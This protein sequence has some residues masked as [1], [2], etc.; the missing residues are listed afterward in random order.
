MLRLALPLLGLVLALVLPYISLL[1]PITL[2]VYGAL[3][4][5][6]GGKVWPRLLVLWGFVLLGALPL[7]VE[8]SS[9]SSLYAWGDWGI[10]HESIALGSLIVLRAITAVGLVA[11]LLALNPV[12]RLCGELRSMGAPRLLVE[13]IELSYRYINLLLST[14]EHIL[15]AQLLRLG[16]QSAGARVQHGGT[17][18]ARSFVL[19]HS[20][21]DDMYEGLLSRQ[22]DGDELAGEQPVSRSVSPGGQVALLSLS[23]LSYR[24]DTERW[25]IRDLSLE[26]RAGE[27]IVLLGANGAGKST[28]MR[29][30]SGLIAPSSGRLALEGEELRG[31]KRD[32]TRQ[33]RRI[34]LVMQNAN[35]QLFCPSVEDEIAFGLKNIGLPAPEVQRRV[36]EIITA[37]DLEALRHRPPHLL[38]EGQK[39][40][41]SIAAVLALDPDIILLDEPTASL[42][43]IYS[44]RVMALLDKLHQAGK[45]IILSTHDMD[46]AYRW[47]E[48]AVVLGDGELLYDGSPSELFA[49]ESLVQQARI[50]IPYGFR[51]ARQAPR[52]EAQPHRYTLALYHST[53]ARVLVVGGGRGA[54]I[55]VRTLMRSGIRPVLLSPSLC[56]ELAELHS[57]AGLEWHRE[58]YSP[59][60]QLASYDLVIAGTGQPEVDRA[61]CQRAMVCSRLCCN[62]SEA[63]GGNVQF[64]AQGSKAGIDLALHSDYRL[65]EVMVALRERLLSEIA[66]EWQE[67]LETLSLLR[68]QAPDVASY[69]T[70]RDT[71]ITKIQ[72]TKR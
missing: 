21:A 17:L 67:E 45:T 50:A 52:P 18:L 22:F 4:G 53:L 62:L 23:S 58:T 9:P 11:L 70:A 6:K 12:Y 71:L 64:A 13:L 35:Y 63:D 72:E 34:A 55:K 43:A 39:K 42:D 30:L 3:I 69:Q 38:S 33:R 27:R 41:V 32:L 61:I 46:R 59:A 60:I 14:G 36:E 44:Q 57:E 48:R 31:T 56:P 8:R 10:S 49:Q 26:I 5:L 28:L 37:Y 51:E 54:F 29:L 2:L 7:F 24:Y 16:Y 40:W 66:L 65:P 25:A 19:A 47:A 68:Q 20:E 1:L 15:E